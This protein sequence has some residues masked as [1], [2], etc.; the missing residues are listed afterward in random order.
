MYTKTLIDFLWSYIRPRNAWKERTFILQCKLNATLSIQTNNPSFLCD[1]LQY[2]I[3]VWRL[4]RSVLPQITVTQLLWICYPI[5]ILQAKTS[6][7]E[8]INITQYP[9]STYNFQDQVLDV[10]DPALDSH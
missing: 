10:K 9:V 5:F 4:N 2:L 3:N 6:E 1:P 7:T 8:D